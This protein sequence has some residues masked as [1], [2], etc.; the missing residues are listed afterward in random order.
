MEH[1]SHGAEENRRQTD[2]RCK[3]QLDAGQLA[4]RLIL[5]QVTVR[6]A[7]DQLATEWRHD[8]AWEKSTVR[9]RFSIME[10]FRG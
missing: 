3:G 9:E 4:T 6:A 1:A 7:F 8:N 10:S 5:R 2:A